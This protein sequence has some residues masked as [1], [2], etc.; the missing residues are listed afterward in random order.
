MS[1]LKKLRS[2]APQNQTSPFLVGS[3]GI[4]YATYFV[5]ALISV[6]LMVYNANEQW[7]VTFGACVVFVTSVLHFGFT[8]IGYLLY[9]GYEHAQVDPVWLFLFSDYF[10]A[11]ALGSA[12]ASFTMDASSRAAIYSA[13]SVIMAAQLVCAYKTTTL[14]LNPESSRMSRLRFDTPTSYSFP[15]G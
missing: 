7:P 1:L 8:A 11:G 10:H 4:L 14:L 9:E 13:L 6:L 2:Y 15:L 12:I 3:V 5:F